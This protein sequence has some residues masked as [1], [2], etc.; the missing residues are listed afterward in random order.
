MWDL[1]HQ[2]HVFDLH[3]GSRQHHILNPLSEVK[4][5]TC[6]LMD[7]SQIGFRWARMG[8]PHLEFFYLNFIG[9]NDVTW[10]LQDGKRI[11]GADVT[12]YK[13]GQPQCLL[14]KEMI[15]VSIFEDVSGICHLPEGNI[16]TWYH[17]Y[18]IAGQ[19]NYHVSYKL[20]PCFLEW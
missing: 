4:D 12:A 10:P 11:Q 16:L 8:T 3:H 18:S 20:L 13:V 9:W 5:W 19:E 7:T 17:A 1:S 14:Q 15:S 2:S 6:I